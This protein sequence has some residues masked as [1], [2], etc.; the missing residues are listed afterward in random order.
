[1][2]AGSGPHWVLVFPPLILMLVV[3]LETFLY[4]ANSHQ[5]CFVCLDIPVVITSQG[6]IL[7]QGLDGCTLL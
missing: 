1:M 5:D 6:D 4:L 7:E 2:F 3:F